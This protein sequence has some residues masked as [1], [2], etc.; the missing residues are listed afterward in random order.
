M[1]SS[2]LQWLKDAFTAD[3]VDVLSEKAHQATIVQLSLQLCT[4]EKFMVSL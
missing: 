4:Y 2:N 3:Q 1:E